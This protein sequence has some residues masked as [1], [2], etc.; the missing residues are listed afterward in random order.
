MTDQEIVAGYALRSNL[1]VSL[2]EVV[3][4]VRKYNVAGFVLKVDGVAFSVGAPCPPGPHVIAFS[5]NSEEIQVIA[6]AREPGD[7][8]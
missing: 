1:E 3:K 4:A 8:E 5:G 2:R 7:G 6:T